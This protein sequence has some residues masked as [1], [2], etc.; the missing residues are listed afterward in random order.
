MMWIIGIGVVIGCT[1]GGYIAAGGHIHV[2]WQP[3]EYIIIVGTALGGMITSCSKTLLAK[4][5]GGLGKAFKGIKYNK[6][7][8]LEM[9]VMMYA[10]FRMARTKGVLAL[11]AHVENPEESSLFQKFPS[12]L[13][14]HDAITFFC[15][16]LRLITMGT[17]S[18][19]Q[20]E[21]LMTQEIDTHHEDGHQAVAAVNSI[22]DSMPAIGIVAAVLGVIHTM[23]SISEPPEVL[24]HLI[25]A[26]LVGTFSGVW[27]AYGYVAPMSRSMDENVAADS[28]YLTVMKAG[29]LAFMQGHAPQIAV[30]FARKNIFHDFRPSF[31]ELEEALGSAPSE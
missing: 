5:L 16:Y 2:L 3:Y 10:V 6:A 8:Y 19:H 28:R 1:L 22:A 14:N 26:A 13:H 25:G 23:G 4:T 11:E 29:L 27:I 15:D 20:M 24:G 9:L 7:S 18:A 21:D 12:V 30:E 17:N 31:Y